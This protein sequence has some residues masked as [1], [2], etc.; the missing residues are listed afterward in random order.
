MSKRI[1]IIDDDPKMLETTRRLLELDGHQVTGLST[2]FGASKVMGDLQP[3]LVL[4][5]VNMPGLSG[6]GLAEV[7]ARNERLAGI[8]VV[9]YSS[10]DTDSL[11]QAVSRLNVAGYIPKGDLLELRDKVKRLSR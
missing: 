7:I 1:L 10:N 2:P 5:D 8:P 6:E 4:L 3:D 11:R 9:F